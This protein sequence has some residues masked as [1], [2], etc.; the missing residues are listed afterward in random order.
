MKMGSYGLNFR[1]YSRKGKKFIKRTSRFRLKK[2]LGGLGGIR[3]DTLRQ[4]CDM[5]SGIG[6]ANG[7]SSYI[8][9]TSGQNYL[10]FSTILGASQPF[11]NQSSYWERYKIT[12]IAIRVGRIFNESL[13][14]FTENESPPPLYISFYPAENGSSL[15]AQPTYSDNNF[16]VDPFI[17]GIQSKYYKTP[18]EFFSTGVGFGIWN[19]LNSY[20][21][22]VGQLSC[23]NFAT[24]SV[25][26]GA[27]VGFE[28]RIRV[29]VVFSGRKGG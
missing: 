1:K 10:A 6:M 11:L 9:G 25:T 18:D 27:F 15:G 17:S 26:S 23:S 22:Q 2:S 28:A 12:G 16:R 7:T 20:T 24:V 14:I 19:N 13:N 5:I 3:G 4:K 21:S 29:Y 8:W